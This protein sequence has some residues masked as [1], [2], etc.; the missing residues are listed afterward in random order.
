VIAP[1]LKMPG[2]KWTL[3]DRIVARIPPH[4]AYV[5]PFAGSLAVFFRKRPAKVEVVNDLD[6]RIVN[7]FRVLRDP[8]TA[9]ELAAAVELTPWSREEY[10][11][12]YDVAVPEDPIEDARRFLVRS[13]QAH[14][15][16]S[17]EGSGWR[18]D[19]SGRRG[20]TC[21]SDWHALPPRL[22]AAVERLR[23]AHVEHK[24]ALEVIRGFSGHAGAAIFADPPYLIPAARRYYAHR[25]D[26]GEHAELLDALDA[27]PGPVLLSGYS[28]P[29]YEERLAHWERETF[30]CRAEKGRE[31]TEVLWLNPAAVRAREGRLW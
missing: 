8:R 26:E 5:E 18:R 25:M 22:L 28:H 7:L 11:G 12:S 14:G 9:R 10:E 6:S 30:S 24:P 27:H 17:S 13:W 4:V 16:K 3:A 21:V 20:S 31:R 19:L 23:G 29:L 2:A 1:V 15:F